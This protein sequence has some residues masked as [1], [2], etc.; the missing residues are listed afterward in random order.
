[1]AGGLALRG[2]RAAPPASRGP[3]SRDLA[4]PRPPTA[5]GQNLKSQG[6]PYAQV[7]TEIPDPAIATWLQSAKAVFL[8]EGFKREVKQFRKPGQVWGLIRQDLDQ[9]QTH[10]RAFDDGRLESEVELSNKFVQHLWSHRRG[11]HEEISEV[12]RKH[13]MPTMHVNE[14]FVPITGTKEGKV[15]PLGRTRNLHAAAAVLVGLGL[16][17]G[18]AYIQ[19]LVFRALPKGSK[20]ALKWLKP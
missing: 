5:T 8:A 19:R 2:W 12:L 17:V 13:G 9:M 20:T 10:V 14:T 1:M 16:L 7:P 18:R 11:A 6:R 15:M 3:A 4:G